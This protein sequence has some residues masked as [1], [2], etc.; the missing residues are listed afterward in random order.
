LLTGSHTWNNLQDWGTDGVVNPIDFDAYV[1]MLVKNHHNFTFVWTVELPHFCNLPTRA[2]DPPA[3]DVSPMPWRRTGPGLATDGKPKFDLNSFDP[4]YFDRLRQRVAQLNAGGIYAGVY[5]FTGEWLAAFR[6]ANDG[7]PLDGRNNINGVDAG[8]GLGAVGM[9]APNAVSAVQDLFVEKMVDTLNDL[10]NVV[11]ATS[12]EA[13]AESWW[14]DHQIDHVRAYERT[15]PF[16]HPI[17]YGAPWSGDSGLLAS[18]ADWV[19]PSARLSDIANCGSGT[20]PCKV[21]LNDSDHSYFG[22]WNDTVQANRA[23]VWGNVTRGSQVSF[24]DPYVVYYPR[25]GRNECSSPVNGICPAPHPRYDNLRANLG[26]TRQYADR[27]D[28]VSMTPQPN[29]TSTGNALATFRAN[30]TEVL[31]YAPTGGTF[32][33]NLSATRATLRVEW[34]NPATGQRIVG[35]PVVGGS[36][37]Q[38]F[39]APFGGDA[40]LYLSDVALGR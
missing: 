5:L 36:G 34:L 11:W 29:I 14:N 26:Y 38:T 37:G 6:C 31:V 28:L 10:P 15:K 27:M 16:Q 23:Y 2:T 39:T 13:P 24:M 20:P 40:V 21:V 8:S 17:G 19:A 9:A 25:E 33:V 18:D 22:M 32:T 35:A 12:E 3:F 7:F 30:A 1:S 4:N